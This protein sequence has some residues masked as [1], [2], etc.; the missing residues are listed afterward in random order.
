MRICRPRST[1]A[2]QKKRT[3][4]TCMGNVEKMHFSIARLKCGCGRVRE[5]SSNTHTNTWKFDPNPEGK[6]H[7][8]QQRKSDI[9]PMPMYLYD[10]Y[11]REKKKRIVQNTNI[12]VCVCVNVSV[13]LPLEQTVIQKIPSCNRT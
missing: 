10:I 4:H 8:D 3:E 6:K 13:P 12:C 5:I 1:G 2:Q 7:D 9:A 11:D